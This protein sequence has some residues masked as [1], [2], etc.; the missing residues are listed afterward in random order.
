MDVSRLRTIVF[1]PGSGRGDV[2][3]SDVAL[4]SPASVQGGPTDLP[5]VGV[6]DVTVHE[7]DADQQVSVPV[8]LSH[9]SPVPVTVNLD[10]GVDAYDDRVPAVWVPVTVPAGATTATARFTIHGNNVPDEPA[11]FHVTLSA[12]VNALVGDG[13]GTVQLLDDDH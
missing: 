6:A 13:W 12:P 3:L 8:V 10:T 1:T 11:T 2:Y 9:A 5:A 7:S 4:D